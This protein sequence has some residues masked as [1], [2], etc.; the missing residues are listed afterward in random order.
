MLPETLLREFVFI[1]LPWMVPVVVMFLPL[2]NDR[3]WLTVMSEEFDFFAKVSANTVPPFR[4]P[5]V[6]RVPLPMLTLLAKVMAPVSFCLIVPTLSSDVSTA[7]VLER[8][9][10]EVVPRVQVPDADRAPVV[11]REEALVVPRVQVPDA[12]RAPVVVRE[13]VSKSI[14]CFTVILPVALLRLIWSHVT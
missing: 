11:D 9:E 1:E 14:G 7:P 5:L 6:S 4:V 3:P 12:D 8:E 10:A 2:A 13:F